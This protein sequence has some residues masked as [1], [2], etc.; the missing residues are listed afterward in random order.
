[1]PTTKKRIS[2]PLSPEADKALAQLSDIS[3]MS[4]AAMISEL[5][6]ESVPGLIK[7]AKAIKLAKKSKPKALALMESAVQ[8][9][10]KE[11]QAAK[12]DLRK[13]MRK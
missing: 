7:T 4:Y 13:E 5:I 3:G 9:T 1:M 2:V 11:A 8:D 10:I 12:R 6:D